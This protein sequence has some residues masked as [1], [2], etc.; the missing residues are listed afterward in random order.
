VPEAVC[1]RRTRHGGHKTEGPGGAG[2]G[3]GRDLLGGASC[4]DTWTTGS[5]AGRVLLHQG[6]EE[7]GDSWN[8]PRFYF[9][10]SLFRFSFSRTGSQPERHLAVKVD[11]LPTSCPGTVQILYCTFIFKIIIN[12]YFYILQL[13][14]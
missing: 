11:N 9:P 3:G 6:W 8:S 5:G 13:K 7:G 12:Y 4:T 14:G 2:G 1:A 10:S